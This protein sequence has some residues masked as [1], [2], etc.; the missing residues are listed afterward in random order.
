MAPS[1]TNFTA[2]S[3]LVCVST[4]VLRMNI[5]WTPVPRTVTLKRVVVLSAD[6]TIT[7]PTI[8]GEVLKLAL[9]NAL[10]P[11]ANVL[12]AAYMMLTALEA[13]PLPVMCPPALALV[14]TMT[15]T[16]LIMRPEASVLLNTFVATAPMVEAAMVFPSPLWSLPSSLSCWSASLSFML[17]LW[18]EDTKESKR[19][20]SKILR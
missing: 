1:L 18:A 10:L 9:P 16:V 2:M 7:A 11:S 8:T 13:K 19:F 20:E 14:V 17:L 4:T 6:P 3:R 15:A 12:L 5:V